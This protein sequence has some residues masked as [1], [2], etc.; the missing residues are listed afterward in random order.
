MSVLPTAA[1]LPGWGLL[2]ETLVDF[3]AC[4]KPDMA[5][6]SGPWTGDGDRAFFFSRAS[7]ALRV[8][9]DA[10]HNGDNVPC[11]WLPD[12][13]CNQALVPLRETETSLIFYPV[14]ETLAPDWAACEELVE[15][16]PPDFFTLV[17]YFGYGGPLRQARQ[18]C[19]AHGAALIEDAAHVLAR[20]GGIGGA[21]DYTIYSLHKHLPIPDGGL[22]VT[23]KNAGQIGRA[24]QALPLGSPQGTGWLV[25]RVL[26]KILP[27]LAPGFRSGAALGFDQDP[28]DSASPQQ[29]ILSPLAARLL[30]RSTSTLAATANQRRIN[31]QIVRAALAG[32]SG[33]EPFFPSADDHT[34]PYRAVFR[35]DKPEQARYWF[36]RIREAGGLVESWPDLPPE[37][38]AAPERHRAAIALRQT[39][40]T[41]PINADMAAETLKSVYRSA[42]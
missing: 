33:I 1:P 22:L 34:A 18:F 25:K 41:I 26:Q 8:I 31:D 40:L 36:E 15:S 27:S 7:W 13:I 32:A 12:Y 24:A 42:V 23:G 10:H 17:H 16:T 37:V 28:A 38:L 3:L 9:V 39:I 2:G 21:G 4:K 14:D 35:A 20:D 19:D 5:R 6:L 30:A 11:L 29:S